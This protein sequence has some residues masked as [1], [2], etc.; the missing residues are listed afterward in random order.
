M[1]AKSRIA[2]DIQ[3]KACHSFLARGEKELKTSLN[4]VPWHAYLPSDERHKEYEMPQTR[5]NTFKS[6][7][8]HSQLI[9]NLLLSHL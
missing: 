2:E 9:R 5:A 7:L 3:V 4:K 6:K 1:V 8:Y